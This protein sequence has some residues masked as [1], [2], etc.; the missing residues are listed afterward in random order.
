M[1]ASSPTREDGASGCSRHRA[2]AYTHDSATSDVSPNRSH[3]CW[4]TPLSR[5][6]EPSSSTHWVAFEWALFARTPE[7]LVHAGVLPGGNILSDMPDEDAEFGNLRRH[8]EPGLALAKSEG[9]HDDIGWGCGTRRKFPRYA[10]PRKWGSGNN[11]NSGPQRLHSRGWGWTCCRAP[12][13]RR[14]CLIR[15]T[16]GGWG[17]RLPGVVRSV[18]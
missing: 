2:A 18:Y 17:T 8:L 12:A 10:R 3:T 16:S 11:S 13:S 9:A 6:E 14:A 7:N 5:C 1:K 15:M 4:W